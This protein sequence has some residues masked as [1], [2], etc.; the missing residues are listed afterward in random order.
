MCTLT[1]LNVLHMFQ[2]RALDIVHERIRSH[3]LFDCIQ[4]L[5]CAIIH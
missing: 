5:S 1:K 2:Y 4:L 3:F